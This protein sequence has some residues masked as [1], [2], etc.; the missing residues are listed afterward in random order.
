MSYISNFYYIIYIGTIFILLYS[1]DEDLDPKLTIKVI[2]IND[3]DRMNSIIE[4]I[5]V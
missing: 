5:L 4:L 1:L 2:V 3:I